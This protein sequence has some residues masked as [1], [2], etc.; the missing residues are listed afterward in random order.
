MGLGT[1][2]LL[3]ECTGCMNVGDLAQGPNPVPKFKLQK[4]TGA[5]KR[6]TVLEVCTLVYYAY[7]RTV[8]LLER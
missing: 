5:D 2:L 8:V 6:Y 1:N 3:V 7:A 4:G